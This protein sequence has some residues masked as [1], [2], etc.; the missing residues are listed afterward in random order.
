MTRLTRA[1][2]FLCGLPRER[3]ADA[4]FNVGGDTATLIDLAQIIAMRV[5]ALL[6]YRP[7]IHTGTAQDTV[8]TGD[9]A[10]K[11]DRLLAAGFEPD[12]TAPL[13]ELDGLIDF[14]AHTSVPP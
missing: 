13:A 1:L 6:N 5:E 10:F 8:G 12:P 9:L 7:G 14:C 4:T 11:S 3:P 2:L